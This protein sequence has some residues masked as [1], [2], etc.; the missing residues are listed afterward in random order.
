MPARLRLVLPDADWTAEY[1]NG[2]VRL[3]GDAGEFQVHAEE[4]GR[5]L[6]SGP[7][8]DFVVTAVASADHV[9]AA[10]DG[11]VVAIKV[12]PAASRAHARGAD[13]D[14]LGP[15]MPATVVRVHVK[16][17]DAVTAG[18]VL[19]ALEAMKMELPIRAPRDG[20]IAAVHCREGELVQPGVTLIELD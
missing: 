20:V 7:D 13:H 19:I 2:R 12:Q 8:G 9:W 5:Y 3:D 14:V 17:G 11:H 10:C 15:P 1:R 4:P 18:D 16:P 6:V